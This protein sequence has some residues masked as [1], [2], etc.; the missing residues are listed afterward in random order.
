MVTSCGLNGGPLKGKGKYE[1]RIAC[2]LWAKGHTTGR[3]DGK[4]PKKTLEAHPYFTQTGKD[5]EGDGDQY[6]ANMRDGAVAGFKFF[7]FDGTQTKL[8]VT[9]SG[10]AKGSFRVS[11]SPDFENNLAW[12][13]VKTEGEK[14][15]NTVDFTGLLG[16]RPLY[17]QYT[18]EGAVD[19]HSFEIT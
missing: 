5:R 19:F 13:P 1:A 8:T 11:D 2:N 10:N 18:G 3:I 16:V 15:E 14:T 12:I 4:N 6:I 9:V 7:E 17:F